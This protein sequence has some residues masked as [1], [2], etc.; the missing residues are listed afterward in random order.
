RLNQDPVIASFVRIS[1]VA[2]D[3][4]AGVPLDALGAPQT[5]VDNYLPVPEACD[6]FISLF[7]CRF[8]TPLPTSQFRKA[9][10]TP[11]LSGSEYEF[12]RA[13]DARRRGRRTPTILVYRWTLGESEI[14][15][16]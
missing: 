12:H 13:W 16:E 3:W 8:G 4:G 1:V 15:P 6:A 5:S 14:C 9:D 10:G 7:R 11:F 2:W